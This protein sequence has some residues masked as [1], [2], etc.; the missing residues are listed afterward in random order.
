MTFTAEEKWREAVRELQMRK[1]VYA[2][3]GMDPSE[4]KRKIAIMEE[5][6]ADYDKLAQRERLL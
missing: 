2:R 4:A 5:I 6:A 3:T 1:S